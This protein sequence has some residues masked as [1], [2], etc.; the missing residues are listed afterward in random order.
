[1]DVV[2]RLKEIQDDLALSNAQFADKLSL[3]RSTLQSL[4]K[5]RNHPSK[6]TMDTICKSL[7]VSETQLLYGNDRLHL[8]TDEQYNLLM[9]W[10]KL[11]EEKKKAI[12]ELIALG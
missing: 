11:S 3:P 6:Q 12:S 2:D 1:V 10:C 4:Y 5:N 9:D 7:K 8:L